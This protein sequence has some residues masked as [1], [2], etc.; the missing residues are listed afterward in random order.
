MTCNN[1]SNNEKVKEKRRIYYNKNKYHICNK[2]LNY[3]C[4]KSM[5]KI[6]S[7]CLDTVNDYVNNYPFEK[8]AEGYI[9]RELSIRKIHHSQGIYADCYDAG[10]LAY[11]YSIHRCAAMRYDHTEFY[12]KK[13]IRVYT[14]CAIFVYN[15]SRNLCK[16]NGFREIKLDMDTSVSRY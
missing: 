12:I 7:L 2:T 15:E 14:N 13:M 11:L 5:E 3:Y 6:R 1:D 9:K 8:Y 4:F 16:T 10:M